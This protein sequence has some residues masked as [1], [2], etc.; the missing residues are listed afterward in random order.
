MRHSPKRRIYALGRPHTLQRFRT[1]VLYF[2]C[3]SLA[4]I[5]FLATSPPFVGCTLYSLER[6][7]QQRQ[8]PPCFL[9]G[10]GRC[11]DTDLHSSHFVYRIVFYFGPD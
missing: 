3:F 4:I 9:I 5:D 6:H 8:Q 2:L 11:D 1:R 10:L 7:S